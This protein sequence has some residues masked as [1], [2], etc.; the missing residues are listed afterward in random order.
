MRSWEAVSSSYWKCVKESDLVESGV[1]ILDTRECPCYV[2]LDRH[3]E[4]KLSSARNSV[5]KFVIH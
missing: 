5:F 1:D 3:S 4:F 2:R